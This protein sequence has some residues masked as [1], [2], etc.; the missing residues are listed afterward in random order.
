MDGVQ[1][2]VTGTLVAVSAGVPLLVMSKLYRQDSPVYRQPWRATVALVLIAV[3]SPAAGY[4]LAGA[5][6]GALDALGWRLAPADPGFPLAV[7]LMV[8]AASLFAAD[9]AIVL[10]LVMR[11]AGAGDKIA[12]D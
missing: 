8:A 4:F 2:L 5:L 3:G 11:R 1:S 7:G 10:T 6:T 9:L 12:S